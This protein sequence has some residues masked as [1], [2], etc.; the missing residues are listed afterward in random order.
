MMWSIKKKGPV[1]SSFSLRVV[2]RNSTPA[3]ALVVVLAQSACNL[4]KS[5][6]SGDKQNSDLPETTTTIETPIAILFGAP[7]SKTR[8]NKFELKFMPRDGVVDASYSYS[9]LQ[10]SS[11]CESATYSSFE[12]VGKPLQINLEKDGK[13]LLC[14][15]IKSVNSAAV[16]KSSFTFERDTTPPSAFKVIVPSSISTTPNLDLSWEPAD[17]A[18]WYRIAV[19]SSQGCTEPVQVKLVRSPGASIGPFV[20]GQYYLCAEAGDDTGNTIPAKNYNEIF[21]VNLG[22][23][24]AVL[25]QLPL[26]WTY[27][28]SL[29]VKVSGEKLTHYRSKVVSADSSCELEDGYSAAASIDQ[30]IV[31]VLQGRSLKLC[32]VGKDSAG[33]WQAF[34]KATEFEW[35]NSSLGDVTFGQYGLAVLKFDT[36]T[37]CPNENPGSE[38]PRT[39]FLR[40]VLPAED[41]AVFVIGSCQ[42]KEGLRNNLKPFLVKLKADGS[43]DAGYGN[44]GFFTPPDLLVGSYGSWPTDLAFDGAGKLLMSAISTGPDLFDSFLVRVNSDGTLDQ[45]FAN[46]LGYRRYQSD[47]VETINAR[48]YKSFK[49]VKTIN[50][51]LIS[52]DGSIYIG[53]NLISATDGHSVDQDASVSY[54]I[55]KL[56]SNG[57]A[58][59]TDNS[60]G[61]G[62]IVLI[63]MQYQRGITEVTSAKYWDQGNYVMEVGLSDLM[64]TD[65]GGLL[66]VGSRQNSCEGVCGPQVFKLNQDGTLATTWGVSGFAQLHSSGYAIPQRIIYGMNTDVY[67]SVASIQ[68]NSAFSWYQSSVQNF[69]LHPTFDS[70]YL[71][72]GQRV[73]RPTSRRD[74]IG[75]TEFPNLNLTSTVFSN[76]VAAQ[77]VLAG[78]ASSRVNVMYFSVDGGA[79]LEKSVQTGILGSAT[80]AALDRNGNAFILGV[81]GRYGENQGFI[82]KI[83]KQ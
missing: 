5:P 70:L 69:D 73:N 10:A 67:Y 7:Q 40:K 45:S 4:S 38:N 9:L 27:N 37:P 18:D 71:P 66:G 34:S 41:G 58:D 25:A 35:N 2:R 31:T 51:I 78:S 56:W 47:S 6:S 28:S 76:S 22:G 30:P 36:T 13:Y 80:D 52:S 43:I 15:Q 29:N 77:A 44:N 53:G 11:S 68:P 14:T 19:G 63:P 81:T 79:F 1:V 65:G 74:K 26:D 42:A 16:F 62:R 82:F 64:F 32:V 20:T 8:L 48:G 33:N 72:T 3:L 59:D 39:V 55:Q 17:G 61:Q 23:P 49:G 54:R 57:V 83:P 12:S 75:S 24:L 60:F 50:K 46:L 21:E